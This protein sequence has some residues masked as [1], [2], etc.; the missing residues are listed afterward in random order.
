MRIGGHN[1][2]IGADPEI[3]V[4]NNEKVVSAHNLVP[5]NKENPFPV[6]NGAVQVDGMAL[7]FNINPAKN[8]K[9]FE[10]NLDSVSSQLFDMIKGQGDFKFLDESSAFFAKEDVVDVPLENLL[11]GCSPD[12]DAWDMDV[13]EGPDMGL[14]T[15]TIMRTA[16]GHVHIGGFTSEDIYSS[17][18]FNNC[19]RLSRILDKNLGVYSLFWDKDDKRRGMYGKAGCFRP[20]TY[21]MEYRT[22]SNKWLFDKKLVKFLYYAV[23]DSVRE[24]VKGV[25]VNDGIFRDIINNSDRAHPFFKTKV[26]MDNLQRI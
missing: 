16:G 22:L 11:L 20:K 19:A 21:G 17:E 10:R 9:E 26:A 14:D 23:K 24:F 7:E 5:G 1:Y 12:F 3:F 6:K 2:T 4:S 8:F 18:H 13:N 15:E 25:D